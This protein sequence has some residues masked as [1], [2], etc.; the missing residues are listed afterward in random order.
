[1]ENKLE[2]LG[3]HRLWENYLIMAVIRYHQVRELLSLFDAS[4]V[5][6]GEKPII[7]HVIVMI[8]V[9][10]VMSVCITL[11][12]G[13]YPRFMY[14]FF[15]CGITAFYCSHWQTYVSGSYNNFL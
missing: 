12:L 15:F 3:H 8:S 4:I 14:F 10:V 7:L 6:H 5:I 13:E 11:K 2:E 9:F 1:M